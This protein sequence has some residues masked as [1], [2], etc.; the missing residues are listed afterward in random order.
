MTPKKTYWFYR[1]AKLV[2]RLLHSQGIQATIK[3]HKGEWGVFVK[4]DE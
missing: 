2:V 1:D 3:K 4:E